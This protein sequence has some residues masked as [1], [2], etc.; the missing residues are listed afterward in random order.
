MRNF[1][2]IF[3]L[4]VFACNVFGYK[5][6]SSFLSA[7][8][9]EKLARHIV[10]KAYDDN[11]LIL[12]KKAVNL[13]YYNLSTNY[14]SKEGSIEI[15]GTHYNFVKSRVVNDTLELLCLPNTEKT[16]VIRFEK[17]IDNYAA[18]DTDHNKDKSKLPANSIEKKAFSD[19][20]NITYSP[21]VNVL[22]LTFNYSLEP[23]GACIYTYKVFPPKPPRV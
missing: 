22:Q 16:R 23:V 19:Y 21:P 12:I 8:A 4:T 6:M 10:D 20:E 13:P 1:S 5:L 18:D 15:E 17:H 3:L 11:E 2:A 7:K 14:E 9:E